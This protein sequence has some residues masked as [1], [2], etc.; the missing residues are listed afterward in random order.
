M[1]LSDVAGDCEV[2]ALVG[3]INVCLMIGMNIN[4]AGEV[5][6]GWCLS[7]RPSETTTALFCLV[8]SESTQ[9]YIDT[10]CAALGK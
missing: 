7:D 10:L 4:C 3:G 1:V 2:I 8:S 6:Q 9:A 5:K